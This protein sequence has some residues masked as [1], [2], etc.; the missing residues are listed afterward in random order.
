MFLRVAGAQLN[1]TV[2]A[3][4]ENTGRILEAMDWA[5]DAEADVLL[6]PELAVTGYPPEDLLLRS[7]F[8]EQARAMIERLAE[9][10]ERCT[11][12]VGFP[13]RLDSAEAEH[14]SRGRTAANAAAVLREGAV[15][16]VYDK[17]LLPNY[18]VFDENRYF[19]AGEHPDLLIDVAGV[20]AGVSVCEDIWRED[21]PRAPRP[22]SVRASC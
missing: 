1:L 16:A 2:G 8:L 12:V 6:L 4:E 18:A 21:G 13:R 17:V 22:T 10:S 11:T 20:R 7:G 5:E 9:A 3:L 14:D 15:V 19:V